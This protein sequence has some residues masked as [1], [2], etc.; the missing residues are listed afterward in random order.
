MFLI[1][2]RTPPLCVPVADAVLFIYSRVHTGRIP[3]CSFPKFS[4]LGP[5]HPSKENKEVNI[6]SSS[7]FY[8]HFFLLSEFDI[9]SHLHVELSV[10]TFP[11]FWCCLYFAGVSPR[12]LSLFVTLSLSLSLFSSTHPVSPSLLH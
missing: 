1:L 5:F 3:M 6:P 11:V 9:R 8:L 2:Q 10:S 12:T 7:V 4:E